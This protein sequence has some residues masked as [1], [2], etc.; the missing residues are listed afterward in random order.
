MEGFMKDRY[1]VRFG[2]MD[3]IRIFRYWE[4]GWGEGWSRLVVGSLM[5][6]ILGI[7]VFGGKDILGS[8]DCEIF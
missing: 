4:R 8:G 6:G 2:T 3:M 1:W 7:V 5:L